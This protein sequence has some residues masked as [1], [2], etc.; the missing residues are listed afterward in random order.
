MPKFCFRRK[1]LKRDLISE[2]KIQSS[3]TKK[4]ISKIK[5]IKIYQ[6]SI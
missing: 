1:R 5:K 3:I 4:Y 6:K 2:R